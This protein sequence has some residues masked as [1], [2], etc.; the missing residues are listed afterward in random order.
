MVSLAGCDREEVVFPKN[1]LWG[2]AMSGFQADMG[3][4][5]LPAQEC[6]DPRSD[7]YAWVT[8]P[9]LLGDPS[10][11]IAGDPLENG[12]GHWELFPQDF[13]RARHEVQLNAVRTSI[14]WSRIFPESTVGL[15]THASLR[16]VVSRPALDHF[17]T[18]HHYTI[19]TWMHDALGCHLD[20]QHCSPRGWL[21]RETMVRE[22]A[23]YA[24]LR[25]PPTAAMASKPPPRWRR[26]VWC[27]WRSPRRPRRRASRSPRRGS[28][29]SPS[30]STGPAATRSRAL[31]DAA[32]WR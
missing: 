12:P 20:L 32:S 10:L 13:D 1:F 17:V 8:T 6:T 18:V 14:E 29:G 2:V 9:A 22:I 26:E 16:A 28:P 15:E 5:T 7:W 24:R 23:K 4:P 30:C 21:D 25:A 27:A 11:Y 19:P 31:S 3:C